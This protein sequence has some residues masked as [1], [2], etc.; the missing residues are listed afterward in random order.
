[1]KKMHSL[2]LVSALAT[3]LAV[4]AIAA[5][6]AGTAKQFFDAYRARDVDAM[7]ALFTKDATFAYVPFGEG[8]T[9]RVLEKGVPT[10]RGLIDAFPDL[11][12]E[13]KQVWQDAPG[14]TAFVD[15]Y[16]GGTQTKDAFGIPNKGQKFWLRHMFVVTTNDARKITDITSYWDNA[17][18][19]SQLGKQ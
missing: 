11:R 13:V 15:V 16:I 18:W 2:I 5:D 14:N 12:N 6:A 7:A 19:F 8:G 1:M 10:W 3:V 17:T 4:P 9:G